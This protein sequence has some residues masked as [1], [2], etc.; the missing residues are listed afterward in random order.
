[1]SAARGGSLPVG[2][3]GSLLT[4]ILAPA[5]CI[6]ADGRMRRKALAK[7]SFGTMSA[8]MEQPAETFD[9]AAAARDAASRNQAALSAMAAGDLASGTPAQQ[10]RLAG[11]QAA[12]AGS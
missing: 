10:G 12:P 4:L 2:V 7:R 11:V 3:V 5:G 9:Q 1:M 6:V 8:R